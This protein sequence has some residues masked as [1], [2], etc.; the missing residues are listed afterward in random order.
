MLLSFLLPGASDRF[1]GGPAG[2]FSKEIK[3][4]EAVVIILAKDGSTFLGRKQNIAEDAKIPPEQLCGFSFPAKS[5]KIHTDHLSKSMME[6]RDGLF[7][8]NWFIFPNL[9]KEK[10]DKTEGIIQNIQSQTQERC[11]C[12]QCP[13]A[14]IKLQKAT[15]TLRMLLKWGRGLKTHQQCSPQQS[16]ALSSPW[17]LMG[18]KR[19]EIL[20]RSAL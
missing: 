4:L 10:Y 18:L 5:R 3:S 20:L 1:P 17:G 15:A 19:F 2:S 12:P 13:E 9:C 16:H 14:K 8:N 7:I 6:F 11:G